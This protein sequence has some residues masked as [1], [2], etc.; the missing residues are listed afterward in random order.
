MVNMQIII[1]IAAKKSKNNVMKTKIITF[2]IL[3]AIPLCMFSQRLPN[4]DLRG[5]NILFE[6]D[7]SVFDDNVWQKD[8]LV[9]RGT[10]TGEEP[11]I[12]MPSN[13]TIE[14]GKLVLR[15]HKEVPPVIHNHQGCYYLG[16]H[17]YTSGEISS[18][19][20]YQYGYY[21]IYAKLPVG[22]GCWPAFWFWDANDS[23]NNPWYNEIDVFE[24]DGRDITGLTC[25]RHW[26][27]TYPIE[28][29]RKDSAIFFLCQYSS[30]Y[31]WYGVKWTRN[32]IIWYL[33][34]S[35]I[36]E[37]SNTY[38]RIGI[39]HP[40][41]LLINLALK[42]NSKEEDNNFPPANDV[43]TM[44]VDQVNGYQL[45]C[46]DKNVVID[47]DHPIDFSTYNWKT[48]KS[49]TLNG[50]TTIPQNSNIVLYATDFVKLEAGFNVPLGAEL[51][52]DIHNECR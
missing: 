33:D 46:T 32:K 8:S 43:N 31:H 2:I 40:M 15:T 22:R 25:N 36:R 26:A 23:Q 49:I 17:E 47:S 51:Y 52:I 4:Q 30:S 10:G 21:E 35:V 11:E 50:N 19:V 5:W 9:T 12:Y 14:N 3:G 28:D 1:L 20:K 7:M 45:D 42:P 27:Y 6:D 24:G 38:G 41:W 13:C 16:Q 29:T 44:Y 18:K 39:H 48:K 37:E 34:R